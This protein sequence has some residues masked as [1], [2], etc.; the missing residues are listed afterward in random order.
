MQCND[1]ILRKCK[2]YQ[3]NIGFGADGKYYQIVNLKQYKRTMQHAQS[4]YSQLLATLKCSPIFKYIEH[5][6]DRQAWSF[7]EE[8]FSFVDHEIVEVCNHF[9]KVLVKITVTYRKYYLIGP[10]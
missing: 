10:L 5:P 9:Q 4:H 6:L 8:M 7:N 3:K 2:S 1:S